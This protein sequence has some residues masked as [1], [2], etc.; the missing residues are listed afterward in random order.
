MAWLVWHVCSY[1]AYLC[2]KEDSDCMDNFRGLGH[3]FHGNL[4]LYKW[5]MLASILMAF[6]CRNYSGY[7]WADERQRYIVTQN[8][9]YLRWMNPSRSPALLTYWGLDKM[10]PNG[11]CSA[12]T[13]MITK[14]QPLLAFFEAIGLKKIQELKHVAWHQLLKYKAIEKY[15]A[16]TIVSWPNPKQ[17]QT[18]HTSDF[19][20]FTSQMVL[21]FYAVL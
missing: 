15:T 11:L 12:T 14:I 3:L 16:H 20:V 13:K 5:W 8:G 4:L 2:Y 21:Y 18:V 10:F 6:L 17:W 1:N 9:P 19:I 7:G